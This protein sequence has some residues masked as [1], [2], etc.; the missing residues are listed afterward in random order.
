MANTNTN[1]PRND[2][3]AWH[4]LGKISAK[5]KIYVDPS[6]PGL[7]ELY[8]EH[9]EKHNKDIIE[10]RFPNSGFDLFIPTTTIIPSESA[11]NAFKVKQ[12]VH[13]EMATI[14]HEYNGKTIH[15]PT[16]FFMM[17]RSSLSNTPLILANHVGLIDS[18]YRGDLTGAFKNLSDE[19]W[20]IEQH[21]RLLQICHPS[22]YPIIVTMVDSLDQ[23][24]TS[25][26]GEGGFGSTGVIGISSG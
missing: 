22:A 26:R 7:R 14:I 13:A 17:P 10:S 16:A 25:E 24:T 19:P 20:K 18:G 23:L 11:N 4:S 6:I 15:F 9:V 1:I 21:T 5:L 12:G 8:K 3:G 2:E